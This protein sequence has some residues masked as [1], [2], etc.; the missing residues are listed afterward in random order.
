MSQGASP[1]LAPDAPQSGPEAE[2]PDMMTC[3]RTLNY[4]LDKALSGQAHSEKKK[5]EKEKKQK[6]EDART[7]RLIL[8]C[9]DRLILSLCKMG[10]GQGGTVNNES[11][12]NDTEL[13]RMVWH[14]VK[15]VLNSHVFDTSGDAPEF[16]EFESPNLASSSSDLIDENMV[17]AAFSPYFRILLHPRCV[18][19]NSEGKRWLS[20]HGLYVSMEKPDLVFLM[21]FMADLVLVSKLQQWAVA[22]LKEIG[23]A[24]NSVAEKAQSL[25]ENATENEAAEGGFGFGK[26][27]DLIS[28][29]MLI[30]A[31]IE[32]KKSTFGDDGSPVHMDLYQLHRYALRVRSHIG[33][34]FESRLQSADLPSNYFRLAAILFDM[35]GF[36]V[37]CYQFTFGEFPEVEGTTISGAISGSWSN[38]ND[39]KRFVAAVHLFSSPLEQ[40]LAKVCKSFVNPIKILKFLGAGSGGIAFIAR[41]NDKDVVFKFC[42]GTG[43]VERAESEIAVKTTFNRDLAAMGNIAILCSQAT[44]VVHMADLVPGIGLLFNEVGTSVMDPDGTSVLVSFM[45]PCVAV[46][47]E[48]HTLGYVHRDP[49]PPNFVCVGPKTR[50]GKVKLIDLGSVSLVSDDVRVVARDAAV[51]MNLLTKSS[52]YFDGYGIALAALQKE[53]G[54]ER[55]EQKKSLLENA[56]ACAVRVRAD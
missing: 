25:L 1:Q 41:H 16:F 39:W 31:I 54:A 15:T 30:P 55:E 8:S 29:P 18:L 11:P 5:K 19:V 23:P 35:N 17:V 9:T 50:R 13:G 34:I 40:L 36:L 56:L 4:L 48:L 38:T 43:R 45:A 10:F 53:P 6:K 12:N 37:L 27:V 42:F 52:G 22:N 51:D 47:V 20:R 21:P 49:R 14:K 32:A 2:R 28:L 33:A 24:F 7:D 46:L 44:K 26:V 3:I